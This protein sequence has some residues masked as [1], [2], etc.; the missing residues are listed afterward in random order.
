MMYSAILYMFQ[1]LFFL[2]T[3]Y[4]SSVSMFDTWGLHMEGEL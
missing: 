2:K 4:Y 1:F 3:T